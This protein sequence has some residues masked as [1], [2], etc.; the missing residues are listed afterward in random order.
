MTLGLSVSLQNITASSSTG[1]VIDLDSLNLSDT[2]NIFYGVAGS[3]SA[4]SSGLMLLESPSGVQRFKV[5]ADGDVSVAGD[6]SVNGEGVCL[7]NGDNCPASGTYLSLYGGTMQGD[8]SMGGHNFTPEGGWI[9]YS[10][11]T[12]GG[13]YIAST[14]NV[15]INQGSPENDLHITNS[16]GNAEIDLQSGTN[17][18]WAIYHASTSEQLRFW[19]SD[20]TGESN[21]LVLDNNG[22]VGIGTVNPSAAHLL[23][24]NGEAY[25]EE[26]ITMN[27]DPSQDEHLVTRGWANSNLNSCED[28]RGDN[29]ECTTEQ[30]LEVDEDTFVLEAGD[31][32]TGLLVMGN[33]ADIDLN[34]N[35]MFNVGVLEAPTGDVLAE[36]TKTDHF[37]AYSSGNVNIW[38][39]LDFHCNEGLNFGTLFNVDEITGAGDL[40][41]N[42]PSNDVYVTED[43]GIG[44]DDPGEKLEV[45]GGGIKIDAD[46]SS[47]PT[48]DSSKRGTFWFVT[49]DTSPGSD[50]MQVCIRDTSCVDNYCWKVISFN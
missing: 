5:E 42:T 45:S 12:M 6:L 26:P 31:T 4:S 22:A 32:M 41:L 25:F 8:L 15:G 28:L 39:H 43:L 48:C 2:E 3:N 13:I 47:R 50:T 11:S 18:Y 33:G 20:I 17:N 21:S 16:G 38:S 34:N 14:S 7:A 49:D 46:G 29:M 37:E 36:T 10:T 1:L 44:T 23:H 27:A 40:I 35:E 30:K 24:V 9:S 19:N